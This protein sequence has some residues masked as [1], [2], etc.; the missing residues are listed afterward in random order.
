[1]SNLTLPF[2]KIFP[3]GVASVARKRKIMNIWCKVIRLGDPDK[4]FVSEQHVHIHEIRDRQ[5]CNSQYLKN[6]HIDILCVHLNYEWK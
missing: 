6:P 2:C 1:M 4:Y 5:V 3:S